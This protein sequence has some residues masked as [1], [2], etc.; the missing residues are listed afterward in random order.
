M[1]KGVDPSLLSAV[2]TEKLRSFIGCRSVRYALSGSAAVHPRTLHF[3][4]GLGIRLRTMYA[5]VRLP[6]LRN[7][8]FC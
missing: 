2:V 5:K 3:Y 8:F 1:A 7:P 6:R 4:A